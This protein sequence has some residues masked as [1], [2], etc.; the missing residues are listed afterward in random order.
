MK[1]QLSLAEELI[2]KL[3]AQRSSTPSVVAKD[4]ISELF[5]AITCHRY[6]ETLR[7]LAFMNMLEISFVTDGRRKIRNYRIN[8]AGRHVL[9]IH[10]REKEKEVTHDYT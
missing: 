7:N 2:L 4:C 8:D 10:R 6:Q 1:I 9:W 5:D 3:A